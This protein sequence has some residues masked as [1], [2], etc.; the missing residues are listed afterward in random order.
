MTG[1]VDPSVEESPDVAGLRKSISSVKMKSREEPSAKK[2]KTESIV[3][4]LKPFCA[5]G[6]R[7]LKVNQLPHLICFGC[8]SETTEPDPVEKGIGQEPIETNNK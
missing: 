1:S 8:A 5:K 3:E 2:V 7:H 6:D 4:A